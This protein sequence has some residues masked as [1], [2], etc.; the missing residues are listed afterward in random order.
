MREEGWKP[1]AEIL[2]QECTIVQAFQLVYPDAWQQFI[3]DT[4]QGALK[5]FNEELSDFSHATSWEHLCEVLDFAPF[6][7]A[8]RIPDLAHEKERRLVRALRNQVRFH[9][10]LYSDYPSDESRLGLLKIAYASNGVWL[11][12]GRKSVTDDTRDRVIE[13]FE[14]TAESLGYMLKEQNPPESDLRQILIVREQ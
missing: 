13:L 12:I 1:M 6:S 11:N 3:D 10:S 9:Y 5:F 7:D 14:K 8:W 4:E 2:S